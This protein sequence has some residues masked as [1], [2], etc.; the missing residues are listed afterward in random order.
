MLAN[1]GSFIASSFVEGT[2]LLL[3]LGELG[4]ISTVDGA[5]VVAVDTGSRKAGERAL[6]VKALGCAL[7]RLERVG[8][9]GE[10]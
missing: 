6:L 2:I 7:A 1:S 10:A 9:V 4:I 5:V 3:A 8:A